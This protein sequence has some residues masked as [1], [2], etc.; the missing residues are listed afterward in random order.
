MQYEFSAQV[1][2]REISELRKSV[3]WNSM[4]ECY[5]DSLNGSYFYV[6]CYE[7]NKLIGFLDVV[8]NGVTDAYIQDVMANPEYQGK[9]I[10]TNLMNH[11]IKK[12]KEDNI[13]MISVLFEES[14]LPFYRKFGFNTILSGQLEHVM[15]I[16]LT[17]YWLYF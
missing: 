1:S 16:K 4:E 12:L 17:K 10:G 8:S 6:C 5:K 13:Y 14:L 15:L 2:P 11:A 9:G 3:G 7:G